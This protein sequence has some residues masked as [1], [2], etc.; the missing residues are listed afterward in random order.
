M[1]EVTGKTGFETKVFL[2]PKLL[3]MLVLFTNIS[4]SPFEHVRID[5]EP[6]YLFEVGFGL[7]LNLVREICADVYM[8][9]KNESNYTKASRG[10]SFDATAKSWL[11]WK[12]KALFDSC[13]GMSANLAIVPILVRNKSFLY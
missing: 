6:L 5:I 12:S 13:L 8:L 11:I 3:K 2:T 4:N 10:M 1:Y 9:L 7:W